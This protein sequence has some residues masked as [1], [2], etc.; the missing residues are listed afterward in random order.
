M[1][2]PGGVFISRTVFNQ[3]RNKLKFGYEYQGEHSVKNIA[4]PVRVYRVLTDPGDAGK[5]IGEENR[6]WHVVI[7]G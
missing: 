6:Y 7:G 3:V 2:E 1:A 4:E 5:V